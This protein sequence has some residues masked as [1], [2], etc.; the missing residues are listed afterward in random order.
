MN[1]KFL[2]RSTWT[3]MNGWVVEIVHSGKNSWK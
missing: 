2:F 1:S 3:W